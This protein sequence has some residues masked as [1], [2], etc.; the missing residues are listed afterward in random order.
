MKEKM[1]ISYGI[2]YSGIR[3][4]AFKQVRENY[5]KD[6]FEDIPGFE[7]NDFNH[8]INQNYEGVEIPLELVEEAKWVINE[9]GELGYTRVWP[10]RQEIEPQKQRHLD[11]L[12]RSE[13]LERKLHRLLSD[14]VTSNK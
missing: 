10:R 1:K 11:F 6:K 12:Q 7:L 5:T 3:A 2:N 8:I 9:V 13:N 4:E 14:A